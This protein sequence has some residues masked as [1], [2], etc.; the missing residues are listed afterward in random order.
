MAKQMLEALVFMHHHSVI[1]T[2]LKPENMLANVN[3]S[4]DV[5]S[6]IKI[7]DFGSAISGMEPHPSIVTTRYYRSPEVL[8]KI[9]YTSPIDV[10]CSRSLTTIRCLCIL[11]QWAIGCIL[12]EMHAGEILFKLSDKQE[13]KYGLI[14]YISFEIKKIKQQVSGITHLAMI[15]AAFGPIPY[16]KLIHYMP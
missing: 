15:E 6:K 2:D 8:L 12:Y 5:A 9:A 1:H 14:H 4:E 11:F 10:V 3:S 13:N 7:I 16:K